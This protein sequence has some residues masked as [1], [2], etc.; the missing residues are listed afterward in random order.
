MTIT[1]AIKILAAIVLPIAT[2]FGALQ[3]WQWQWNTPNHPLPT[4]HLMYEQSVSEGISDHRL[5]DAAQQ[6]MRELA[7]QLQTVS[8]S[9]AMSVDGNLVWAGTIGLASVEPLQAAE[10]TTQYRIGSVSKSI[11]T[12]TLMRMAE[13]GI[14]NLDAPVQRYLPDY[15][16]HA[17]N[18]TLRQ[19]ANHTG[20]I[21]HYQFDITRFPPTD[22]V[23][24]IAYADAIAA[25]NQFKN[26]DLLFA[27]GKGFQYSTH[28]YTLLSAAMQAAGGKRFSALIDELVIQPLGLSHTQPEHLL[29]N[30]AQLA[31]FYKS[32]EGMY[33]VTAAQNLSNKVAGGGYVS[34]PKD[35]VTLGDAL[36]S[37]TLL[38][39][40]SFDEMTQ[41]L[42]MHDGGD[43]PQS[44][45]LGWRHYK[46][47]RIIDENNQV[48]IIHH[49]GRAF[50]ADCFLMLVPD[51]NIS[52]AI[53]TNG[54]SNKSRG[55][56]QK[57]AYR[58]AAMVIKQQQ[59]AEG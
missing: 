5:A 25:L 11:T 3:Y 51:Y 47:S 42:P 29:S 31:K 57:L 52:V 32:D 53:S 50:G 34:T 19:L 21:R 38:S 7:E 27:P 23:S 55:E 18:I 39:I 37:N 20:G 6:Q 1:K 28:G 10:T 48:D 26:D 15:P 54:Q 40:E 59:D 8:M 24:N 4:N 45:A 9:G 58:L 12:V 44:Y 33:G 2:Y 17:A 13:L 56:I 36:L 30:T 22:S 46:T 35:L 41:V 16:S 49:G 43:N 14:L